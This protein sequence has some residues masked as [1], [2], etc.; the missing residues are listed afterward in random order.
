VWGMRTGDGGKRPAWRTSEQAPVLEA[1]LRETLRLHP[2]A[3]F[4]ARKLVRDAGTWR[5]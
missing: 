3:P 5:W 2:V 1:V 4:V